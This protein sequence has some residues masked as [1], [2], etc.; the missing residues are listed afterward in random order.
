MSRVRNCNTLSDKS[1]AFDGPSE[2]LRRGAPSRIR[3]FGTSLSQSQVDG[4]NG[5]LDAFA[6]HGD[7]RDKTIAYA[8]AMAR[9]AP[10][11]SLSD[12]ALPGCRHGT[13][14][15]APTASQQANTIMSTEGWAKFNLP[16]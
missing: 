15:V 6:T 16:G 3:C 2:V 13:A 8:L 11:W 7:K 10:A 4:V 14:I 12:K 5:I 1:G 9:S